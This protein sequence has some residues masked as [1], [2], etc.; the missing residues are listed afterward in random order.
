MPSFHYTA[1]RGPGDLVE[2]DI[3]AES[4]SG[5]L[6]YLTE[7]GYVPVRISETGAPAPSLAPA[8][9]MER[10]GRVPVSQLTAFTR[11]F[12]SLVRSQVPLLR[13][14]QILQEQVRHPYFRRVLQGVGEGVRQGETLSAGLARFP[15]V[16][17]PLYTS[18]IYSGEVSGALDAVLAQL[19]EQAER[20]EA[21]RAKVR[22][23]FTYP[24]FVAVVGCGTV[25]FLMTFVMP[26]LSQ[27]L[28]GLGEQLPLPTRL[29]LRVTAVMSSGWCWSA[30]AA[31]VCLLALGWRMAGERG[32]LML[33]R[34]I[35]R[36]PGVGP[37]VQEVELARFARAFGL[38]IQHGIS[39][40]KAMEV[41]VPV[42]GHRVVRSELAKIP[43]GLRQGSSLS[44]CL[45]PLAV[46]T[47]FL[48]NTVAVGEES[49]RVG[50]ALT[51]VA[52]YYEGNT[53]RTLQAMASLLEPALIVVIGLV[54]GFIVMAVLLPIFEMSSITK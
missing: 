13:T 34:L 37:M 17:S 23:A 31:G 2:G 26:R 5:V 8:P 25:V 51:E 50:E 30:V 19:A 15:D 18:L 22:A 54:V 10:R 36:L 39:V 52:T 9:K 44:A 33:D 49:G 29:L 4:R 28:L 43:E 11:Q 20:D 48:V 32:R 53:E 12:A 7:L 3:E 1:K 47:P 40:L 14:L 16:F 46:S 45:R 27:L 6:T 24:A 38:L 21:L 42:V 41:A 35:L